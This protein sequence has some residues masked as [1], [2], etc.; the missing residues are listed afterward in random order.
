MACQ[1]QVYVATRAQFDLTG[2][3]QPSGRNPALNQCGAGENT[4]DPHLNA[5]KGKGKTGDARSKLK[6]K[7]K[8]KGKGKKGDKKPKGKGKGKKKGGGKNLPPQ[9][10]DWL[11]DQG[12]PKGY[13][14]P[15]PHFHK[16]NCCI[17]CGSTSHWWKDCPHPKKERPATKTLQP[18]EPFLTEEEEEWGIQDEE[19]PDQYWDPDY[20]LDWHE[21]DEEAEEEGGA[22]KRNRRGRPDSGRNSTR[23]WCR[24]ASNQLPPN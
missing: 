19:D 22:R 16:P 4:D 20:A 18:E 11:S 15:N 9:C 23:G 10:K 5:V 14:C 24:S 3:G 7:G 8:G 1:F 21:D 6:K 12:C 17:N 13:A 2:H